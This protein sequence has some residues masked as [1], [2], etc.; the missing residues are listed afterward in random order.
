L[1]PKKAPPIERRG[2]A[3]PQRLPKDH[4]SNSTW[5]CVSSETKKQTKGDDNKR[6]NKQRPPVD[7]TGK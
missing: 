6:P 3:G 4:C 7:D 1:A 5:E 2:E